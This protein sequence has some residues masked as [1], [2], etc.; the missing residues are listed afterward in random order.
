[1]RAFRSQGHLAVSCRPDQH[2]W[3]PFQQLSGGQQ[4]LAA[5]ALAFAAHTISGSTWFL[6]DEVDAALDVSRAAHLG[7]YMRQSDTQ[8]VVV[9]HKP[10]ARSELAANMGPGLSMRN[11]A[12]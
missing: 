8:F 6:C 10:Q 2:N 9:S 7:A 3:R 12:R 1:M 4:A 5:L 11:L